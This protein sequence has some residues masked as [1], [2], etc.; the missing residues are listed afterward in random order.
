MQSPRADVIPGRASAV[1]PGGP[2]P[3]LVRRYAR[4]LRSASA[5]RSVAPMRAPGLRPARGGRFTRPADAAARADD[6]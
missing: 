2:Q 1:T 3:D 4:I 5:S 6:A